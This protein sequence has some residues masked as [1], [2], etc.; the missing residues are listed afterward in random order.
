MKKIPSKQNSMYL[1]WCK[2]KKFR[3]MP[4]YLKTKTQ[5]AK[6]KNKMKKKMLLLS[7]KLDAGK[8]PTLKT[9]VCFVLLVC[10]RYLHT[11]VGVV[12]TCFITLII[13]Y[14]YI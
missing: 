10:V 11:V 14:I 13:T 5:K 2:H 7:K 8:V 6:N 1:V 9:F 12:F 3:L 4:L